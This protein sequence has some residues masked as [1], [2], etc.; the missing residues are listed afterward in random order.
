MNHAL[1]E[2]D[3][4]PFQADYERATD[5]QDANQMAALSELPAAY[6]DDL[7]ADRPEADCD[8]DDLR[9]YGHRING[10]PM[11]IMW[12]TPTILRQR[13]IRDGLA[14]RTPP[15]GGDSLCRMTS[16]S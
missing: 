12:G 13:V 4:W 11:T 9:E 8:R 2:V 1:V 7:A 14:S 5:D 10:G 6:R 16:L 15:S 3:L